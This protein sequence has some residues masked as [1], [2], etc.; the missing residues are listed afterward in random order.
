MIN[1]WRRMERDHHH[2]PHPSRQVDRGGS[3]TGLPN[4]YNRKDYVP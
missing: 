2:A 1:L 3:L 4:P